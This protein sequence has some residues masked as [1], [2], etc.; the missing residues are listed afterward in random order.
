MA[1]SAQG[2]KFSE[3]PSAEISSV[4]ALMELVLPRFTMTEGPRVKHPQWPVAMEAPSSPLPNQIQPRGKDP[5]Y[6]FNQSSVQS[7]YFDLDALASSS[8]EES[9]E[10]KKCKDLSVTV[11]YKLEEADTLAKSEMRSQWM[12]RNVKTCR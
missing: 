8:D 6:S 10:V 12:L 1:S 11:L 4:Q 7:V 2:P 9:V 3:R 5:R